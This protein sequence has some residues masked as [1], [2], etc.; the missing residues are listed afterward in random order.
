MAAIDI[1][2]LACLCLASAAQPQ[3]CSEERERRAKTCED[4]GPFP[5]VEAGCPSP[6]IACADLSQSFADGLWMCRLSFSAAW[7]NDLPAGTEGCIVSDLCPRSCGACEPAA[8]DESGALASWLRDAVPAELEAG[9]TG[10]TEQQAYVARDKFGGRGLFGRRNL[11]AGEVVHVVRSG[12]LVG[13]HP[14]SGEV[15]GTSSADGPTLRR[16]A[17]TGSSSRSREHSRAR[18]PHPHELDSRR[19]RC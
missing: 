19:C 10:H 17:A 12:H 2:L 9:L 4:A 5:C 1:L 15:S 14:G 7:D 18:R 16:S 11:T 8:D 6:E 3:Q 13:G